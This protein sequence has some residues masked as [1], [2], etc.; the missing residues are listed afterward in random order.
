MVYSTIMPTDK[1]LLPIALVYDFDGTLAEGNCAEHGLLPA[2][3]IEDPRDFW[4]NVKH[5]ATS[6]DAD[7]IL[8]YLGLLVE[9]ASSKNIK[10]ISKNKLRK[11]GRSI[12]LFSGVESWFPRINQYAKSEG[13]KLEHYIISSGLEE[14]IIGCKIGNQFEK[15]FGCRIEKLQ[16]SPTTMWPTQT[17]NYTTKTQFLF[18]INKGIN[19]S[20]DNEKINRFIEPE[21]RPIPFKQMIFLGDGDTD[22]PSMKMVR[23][24][25]GHSLAV[26]DQKKWPSA[27]TQRKVGKL[28]SEERADYVVP[29]DYKEGSQ[30]DVTIKGILQLIKRKV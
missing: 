29:A 20:W 26:F 5:Q 27:D 16:D 12:P 7:E 22:I 19:N 13:I 2:L 15:I 23:Y 6:R 4:R 14:M 28:I 10:L 21:D 18:R 25:G 8:T 30:L 24:Q 9:L 17:I 3:G 11:F 1:K